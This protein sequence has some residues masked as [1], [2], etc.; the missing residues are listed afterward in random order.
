MSDEVIE[1]ELEVMKKYETGCEMYTKKFR[2]K[3]EE[4]GKN[5]NKFKILKT[6]YPRLKKLTYKKFKTHKFEFIEKTSWKS[7]FIEEHGKNL[8]GGQRQRIAIARALA[9]KPTLLVLDE[10]TNALDEITEKKVI[11]ALRDEDMGLIIISHRRYG[12]TS[13]YNFINLL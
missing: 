6:Q 11:S 3:F 10:A 2:K 4:C 1:L 8:S 5:N 7:F 13:N 12:G 9:K